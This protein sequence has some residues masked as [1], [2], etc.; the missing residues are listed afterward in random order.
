MAFLCLFLEAGGFGE[1]LIL[2]IFRKERFDVVQIEGGVGF[3][4]ILDGLGLGS[5]EVD[6]SEYVGLYSWSGSE[7]NY[8]RA[9]VIW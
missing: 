3:E 1:R 2:K 4:Q 9:G 6:H 8:E 5:I 7:R